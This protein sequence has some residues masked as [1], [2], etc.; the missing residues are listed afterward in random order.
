MCPVL[1]WHIL[2]SKMFAPL[3]YTI[4]EDEPIAL[5]DHEHFK[6]RCELFM[7]YMKNDSGIR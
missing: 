3:N 4:K 5:S 7:D 2:L 6:E 1:D